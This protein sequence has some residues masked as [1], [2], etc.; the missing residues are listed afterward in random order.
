ME[1]GNGKVSSCLAMFEC[2]RLWC[3]SLFSCVL[4]GTVVLYVF[5]QKLITYQRFLSI[6]IAKLANENNLLGHKLI[7][8]TAV[9]I[10]V[11]LEIKYGAKIWSDGNK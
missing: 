8:Y 4:H 6:L 9:S 3:S 5:G 2:E 10:M 1:G 11:F 7:T